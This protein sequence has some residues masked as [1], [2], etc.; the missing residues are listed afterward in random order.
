MTVKDL[1]NSKN[2]LQVDIG[3][4]EQIGLHNSVVYTEIK[5][6]KKENS[7][8]LFNKQ[9]LAFVQ[10]RYLPFFS[11]KTIQ[12]SLGFLLDKGYITADRIKPEEAKE[13]VLKNKHNCKFKCE[14][15]GCGCNVINEHHYPIPKSMG[16]TKIV[17]ICPNCHYE[18]HSLYK[19]S[20]KDGV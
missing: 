20:R 13:I 8:D 16:G 12:R 9:D 10:K 7:I 4:A 19:I 11:I 6:A 14:W 18:F 3:L 1:F 17:R 5:K 2:T 15:C